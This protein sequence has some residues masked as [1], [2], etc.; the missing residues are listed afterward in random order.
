M[1]RPMME[2][3]VKRGA[4]IACVVS[5][6]LSVA[7]AAGGRQDPPGPPG[8]TFSLESD[9]VVLHVTVLTRGGDAVERLSQE[10][11]H[12]IE[13][14]TPQTITFFAGE[15]VPVAVGLL[16]DNSSSMLTRRGM[17]MAG[18]KAFAESSH[19]DDEAFTIIFN[20]HVQRGLPDGVA[21]TH[22][23]TLL[24]STLGRF[25]GGG[26]TALHDAV[27]AGLDHLES[28]GRQ[29][30]VLVVLSDGD[31]NASRHSEE[32]MLRRAER[33]DALIYTLS[34][35]RLDTGVGN[36]RLLRKLARLTGG[37]SYSP[38]SE[39]QAVSAFTE[40]AGRVRRGYSVGYV[41]TNGAHDG[42][43]RRVIVQVRSAGL[44]SPAVHT[45]EGYVAPLHQHGR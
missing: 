24:Q 25:P 12:V 2:P 17:V 19:P 15:D 6:A 31:D 45:R 28:A 42:T 1:S 37:A 44:K 18:V 13:N 33:S 4:W 11:F 26:M 16:V 5:C 21:F 39:A 9:L 36:E 40:I 8:P 23:S 34:T 7:V 38:R 20:E 41:P 3:M 30:H 29:K 22:N 14:G 27:I 43:Y 35:A 10:A 32:E